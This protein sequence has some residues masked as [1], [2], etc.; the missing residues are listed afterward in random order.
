MLSR[1]SRALPSSSSTR[2]SASSIVLGSSP[3]LPSAGN[4]RHCQNWKL[5]LTKWFCLKLTL[6]KLFSFNTRHKNWLIT[7]EFITSTVLFMVGWLVGWLVFG[8]F[9]LSQLLRPPARANTAAKFENYN[10][11]ECIIFGC[12]KLNEPFSK[13]KKMGKIC[14]K[15]WK[16]Q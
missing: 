3:Q 14:F 15:L 4:T 2:A 1:T 16:M 11:S 13:I 9:W 8:L 5:K 6:T 7:S 10:D 12:S